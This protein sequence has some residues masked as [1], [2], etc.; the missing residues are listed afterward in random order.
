MRELMQ[1]ICQ[2]E[3]CN[4]LYGVYNEGRQESM[5]TK[6]LGLGGRQTFICILT[7]SVTSKFFSSQSLNFL[8]CKMER[9]IVP[10]SQRIQRENSSKSFDTVWF[11]WGQVARREVHALL[12]C[13]LPS[14]LPQSPFPPG[15]RLILS[16]V[17]QKL[18][19]LPRELEEIYIHS[20]IHFLIHSANIYSWLLLSFL[21]PL[22][23]TSSQN[24][25]L[26]LSP[27]SPFSHWQ[28]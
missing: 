2:R 22:C 9:I 14:S 15:D 3:S 24:C 16:W 11:I 8:I 17:S 10:A 21:S 18:S 27:E 26:G 25:Q 5:D 20:S 6:C 12:Y 1:V 28:P 4:I 13:L 19:A 23:W 7:S